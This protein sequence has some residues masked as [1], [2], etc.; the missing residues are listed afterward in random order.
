V[1]LSYFYGLSLNLVGSVCINL[2]TNIIK[3][4]HEYRTKYNQY[5]AAD[6]SS[7]GGNAG[8]ESSGKQLSNSHNPPTGK[9][10]YIG[11]MTT[12][13]LGSIVNFMSFGFAPQSLLS[14]LG[15]AQFVSNVFF[16]SIILGEHVTR[17]IVIGTFVIVFGNIFVVYSFSIGDADQSRSGALKD[18]NL[19]Q[20][21]DFEDEPEMDWE[22]TFRTLRNNFDQTFIC[23]VL[24]SICCALYLRQLYRRMY[25]RAHAGDTSQ[26]HNFLIPICFASYS[27]M[28]GAQSILL[29]KSLSMLVRARVNDQ[30]V[31]SGGPSTFENT[32]IFLWILPTGFWLF[33]LNRALAMFDGLLIIPL[34][35]VCWTLS[36]IISGGV[37][38]K[39]FTN[40]GWNQIFFFMFGII[41]VLS[42]VYMLF[43][44]SNGMEVLKKTL[45]ADSKIESVELASLYAEYDEETL[46]H[47]DHNNVHERKHTE[48]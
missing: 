23:F 27:A 21:L 46:T 40:F 19:V 45:H 44:I 22:S 26:S 3:L 14:A 15:S 47:R 20:S 9:C 11:G 35:H 29:A 18:S 8:D 30:S 34:M 31:T 24:V 16:G 48:H 28:F 5:L 38:F 41:T 2:G 32:L 12:F 1:P 4:A 25:E 43:P 39:E 13:L 10:W 17:R 42:G 6:T 36:S 7:C 33:Q 37:F